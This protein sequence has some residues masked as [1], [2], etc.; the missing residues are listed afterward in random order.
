MLC[1]G[2]YGK[3]TT[4][5]TTGR[6]SYPVGC[7]RAFCLDMVWCH[8]AIHVLYIAWGFSRAIHVVRLYWF[9]FRL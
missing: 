5:E 1:L 3:G 2:S 4:M 6:A 9:R 7:Y 8:M